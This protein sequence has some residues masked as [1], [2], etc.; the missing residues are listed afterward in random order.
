ME[1]PIPLPLDPAPSRL[2]RQRMVERQ[3]IPRGIHD[4]RVLE[5]MARIP[6]EA[7]L[8]PSAR[9]LAYEDGPLPIGL[10]QTISQPYMVAVMAQSLNLQGGEQ[11]LEVGTGSGYGAAVL[12][13]LAARVITLERLPE[14]LES[15][16]ARWRALG[17]EPIEGHVSDGT[18]G[19]PQGAPFEAICVTAAA[20]RIPAPLLAQLRRGEGRLVIPVGGRHLQQLQVALRPRSGPIRITDLF[21]CVFVPLIGEAGWPMT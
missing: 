5:A 6:R 2:A 7:F 10:G 9:H 1:I 4:S 14:L 3:L 17:L 8:P 16:Q 21:P 19:W 15:A 11:V 12:A 18:L 20:P 13:L